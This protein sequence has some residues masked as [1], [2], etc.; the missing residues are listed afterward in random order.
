MNTYQVVLVGT[1]DD[2]ETEYAGFIAVTLEELLVI[3]NA[4]FRSGYDVRIKKDPD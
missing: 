4:A 3:I 2:S 1:N